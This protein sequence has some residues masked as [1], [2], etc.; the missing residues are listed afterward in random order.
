MI[1][2]GNNNKCTVDPSYPQFWVVLQHLF[3]RITCNSFNEHA[4]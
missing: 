3:A 1:G 4:N 2:H